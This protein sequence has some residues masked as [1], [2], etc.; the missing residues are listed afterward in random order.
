MSSFHI[1][2]VLRNLGQGTNNY[3]ISN[4][5]EELWFRG[6]TKDYELQCLGLEDACRLNNPNENVMWG[7]QENR[8]KP[9][10]QLCRTLGKNGSGWQKNL[11]PGS[12]SSL[13]SAYT[14]ICQSSCGLSLQ[15][16]IDFWCKY[17]LATPKLPFPNHNSFT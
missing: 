15:N 10:I 7:W 9:K 16:A 14:G 8:T 6:K 11:D 3:V 13:F 4:Y 12:L 17:N 5:L 1:W 2:L